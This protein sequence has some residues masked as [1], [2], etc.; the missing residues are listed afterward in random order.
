MEMKNAEFN[1]RIRDLIKESG[2]DCTI[3]GMGYGEG[4]IEGL[5]M[6]ILEEVEGVIDDSDPSAKCIRHEPYRTI[7]KNIFEHFG[8]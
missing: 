8:L 4:N 1:N 7:I 6:L 2:C 3:D 5:V